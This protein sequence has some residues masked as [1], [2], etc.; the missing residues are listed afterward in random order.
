MIYLVNKNN[1]KKYLF[2][3]DWTRSSDSCLRHDIT[4]I[5][6]VSLHNKTS[7]H[8][9]VTGHVTGRVSPR[10]IHQ[11][12]RSIYIYHK[13]FWQIRS[14]ILN[15]F[16]IIQFFYRNGMSKWD[17]RHT[18][19]GTALTVGKSFQSA[20]WIYN[21]WLHTGLERG[22]LIFGCCTHASDGFTSGRGYIVVIKFGLAPTPEAPPRL[23]RRISKIGSY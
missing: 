10:D 15:F 6:L 14:F 1:N 20:F 12:D 8:S 16:S 13:N 17:P 22:K 7:H 19:H 23:L 9:R 18:A 5:S 2:E 21:A 11:T 4:S 3:N